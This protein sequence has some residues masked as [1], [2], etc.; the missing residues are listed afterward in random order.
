MADC[1]QAFWTHPTGFRICHFPVILHGHAEIFAGIPGMAD[2]I[3]PFAPGRLPN[4][5]LAGHP[6]WI[7]GN[8]CRL[9]GYG[10]RD[11]AFCTRGNKE[12]FARFLPKASQTRQCL[13]QKENLANVC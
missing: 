10:G 11:Q 5:P 6:A 4:L 2:A 9:S 8:I 12:I 13:N 7:R 1:D 3:K